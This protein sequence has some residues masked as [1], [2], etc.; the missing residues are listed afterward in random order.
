[1]NNTLTTWLG[2]WNVR[3][4]ILLLLYS[5][6]SKKLSF[7]C[8]PIYLISCM[9]RGDFNKKIMT[10][11]ISNFRDHLYSWN[12]IFKARTR[13]ICENFQVTPYRPNCSLMLIKI[14]NGIKF[15]FKMCFHQPLEYRN[16][17]PQHDG[18]QPAMNSLSLVEIILS[19]ALD[20]EVRCRLCM[21][22]RKIKMLSLQNQDKEA[23][24]WP[25]KPQ[26]KTVK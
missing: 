13:R 25:Q 11:L 7:D 4:V 17:L 24:I 14:I 2:S 8:L 10:V 12:T 21:K 5:F 3:R 19:I 16:I 6:P 23:K 18:S 20:W 9:A 1:M 15:L 26:L 22:A